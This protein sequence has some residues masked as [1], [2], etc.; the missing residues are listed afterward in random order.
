MKK[1]IELSLTKSLEILAKKYPEETGAC[2]EH[3][4]RVEK[5]NAEKIYKNK[6]KCKICDNYGDRV[7][8]NICN[9]NHPL[10]NN[11]F[12]KIASTHD[13]YF[14]RNKRAIVKK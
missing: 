7:S 6:I 12:I 1:N 5:I 9:T 14:K 8:C 3:N 4:L 10:C 2:I 13:F 11:C